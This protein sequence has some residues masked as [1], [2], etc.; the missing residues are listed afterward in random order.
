MAWYKIEI[1]SD[2]IKSGELSDITAQFESHLR[3]ADYEDEMALFLVKPE[4]VSSGQATKLYFTPSAAQKAI[5]ILI[6][7]NGK[8]C[9]KPEKCQLVLL[10]GVSRVWD[11]LF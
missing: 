7:Y 6:K 4:G 10:V 1:E 8:E 5:N 3:L 9:K 2:K 11:S